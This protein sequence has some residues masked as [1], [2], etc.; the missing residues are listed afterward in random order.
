MVAGVAAGLDA[1]AALEAFLAQI[2]TPLPGGNHQVNGVAL[3]RHAQPLGTNP[4]QRA[5]VAALE[6]VLTDDRFLRRHHFVLAEG[7]LHAQDLGAV[8]QALGML[9]Q[10]E[11][12]RA[13]GGI[14]GAH[15]FEGAATVVQG[16]REHMDLGIAPVHQLAVH[17]DLAV[18]VGHAWYCAHAELLGVG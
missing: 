9:F 12:C 14:V 4:G 13:T 8:E 18:A 16:M 2:G 17:P 7:N 6:L 15:A 3:G 1:D 5:Q 11:D 10:P